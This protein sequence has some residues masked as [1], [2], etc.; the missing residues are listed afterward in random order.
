MFNMKLSLVNIRV[1]F[2]Y[3]KKMELSKSSFHRYIN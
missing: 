3:V 2:I 1:V